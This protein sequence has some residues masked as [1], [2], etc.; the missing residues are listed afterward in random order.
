MDGAAFRVHFVP[1]RFDEVSVTVNQ[2]EITI[3]L[4]RRRG[5]LRPGQRFHR[6]ALL[7][8]GVEA[9][10]VSRRRTAG[11]RT[12]AGRFDVLLERLFGS[13]RHASEEAVSLAPVVF[14][15]YAVLNKEM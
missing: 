13:V 2:A 7:A 5:F 12:R 15:D 11:R 9:F 3:A 6:D 10:D 8:S 1:E 4:D 14:L